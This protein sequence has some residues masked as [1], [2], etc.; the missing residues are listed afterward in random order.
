MDKPAGNLY[1]KTDHMLPVSFEM[2]G[3]EFEKE[4]GE[5]MK[6]RL[7]AS[8]GAFLCLT[9][10]VSIVIT[11]FAAQNQSPP[12]ANT[13]T[14]ELYPTPHSVVY[15]DDGF[16]LTD[17]VTLICGEGIDAPT[18]NRAVQALAAQDI[19][20]VDAEQP[21]EGRSTL[22]IGMNG[23]GSAADA[24]TEQN[25]LKEEGLFDKMDSYILSA[26]DGM[27]SILGKDTDAAF[28]GATTLKHILEQAQDRNIRNLTI[29]D[30]SDSEYRG[31]IEGYYGLPWSNEDRK[32]LM[33][34]GG[35][36]KMTTYVFAPK[37]DPYHNEHWRTLYPQD[38]LDEI[39]DMVQT[40]IDSKCRFVWTIHPFMNQGINF[41]ANYENDLQVIKTKFQQL[42]DVGVR[43][44][45][46]LADD[47]GALSSTNMVRLMTDLDQWV[48]E[49]E[50]VEDLL[51]CPPGYNKGWANVADLQTWRTM[52]EDVHIFWTGD[53]VC[54]WVNQGTFDYFTQH[55]GREALMWLNW[56]VNDINKVRLL[57][58]PGEVMGKNVTG[59]E[60]IV[61]NPMQ[62]AECSKTALFA[63]ADYTWN[64]GAFN[65]DKSWEDCFK[66]IEPD[67]AE[68]LH[69]MAKHLQDP[70]PN[71]HGLSLPESVELNPK[72]ESFKTKYVAGE[73]IKEIGT[74]LVAEFDQII[75]ATEAFPEKSKNEDLKDEM[76]PWRLSLQALSKANKELIQTAI[77][78]EEHN[79]DAVWAH[80][81][82]GTAQFALSKTFPVKNKDAVQLVE[83]GSK[84]LIPFATTLSRQLSEPVKEIVAPVEG[85][86]V[87]SSLYTN[88]TSANLHEGNLNNIVDGN[89][90]T[91]AWINRYINQGDYVGLQFSK[92][93]QITGVRVVQGTNGKPKDAFHYGKFQYSMDGQ[94]WTDLNNGQTYGPYQTNIQLN[95]L[96]IT[97]KYIRFIQDGA[98][99]ADGEANPKWP[100]FRTFEVT[101][102]DTGSGVYTNV[103]ALKDWALEIAADTATLSGD[104]ATLAAGEYVGMKLPRIRDLSSVVVTADGAEKLTLETSMNTKEWSAFD[105]ADPR[106][107]RYVRLINRGAEAVV[108][109]LDALT[110]ASN[111]I[112]PISLAANTIGSLGGDAK[113]LFDGDWTTQTQFKGSQANGRY[114]TYDLGQVIHLDSLKFVLSDGEWDFPRNADVYVSLDNANWEKILTI[115]D[116]RTD[117]TLQDVF[118]AHEI[119][120]NTL[121]QT[122]IDK[123][124]RYLK[125]NLTSGPGPSDKWV[126]LNEIVLNGGAYIPQENN[127]TFISDPVEKQGH[128]A[129]NLTD[130][131]LSTT[132][133]PD[134]S[135]ADNGVLLYRLSEG[136]SLRQI[137]IQQS[138]N[139]LSNA[140]VLVRLAGQQNFVE[141]GALSQSFNVFDRLPEG[142]IVELQIVWDGIAPELHELIVIE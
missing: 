49:K 29:C 99:K 119:S 61:S 83:A 139:T 85:D 17:T 34:F 14:Y 47:A 70:T 22:L 105:P 50:G 135:K 87:K 46:V 40:G 129:S 94:T 36:F 56:P 107:A 72:L 76:E 82:E 28:Y 55:T 3:K 13:D 4:E 26:N 98:L 23:D 2:T 101:Q 111:E 59:F 112:A 84:R 133:L 123:D 12:R 113:N 58:G 80:Y 114:F 102:K 31:F 38:K 116:G 43:Q 124:V 67:A 21:V 1:N 11:A 27:I 8:L 9:L 19:Q 78:L 51:F 18:K 5:N 53:G 140:R 30:Y 136:K 130:G 128:A 63:V 15:A 45:G 89:D 6:K 81:S 69:T 122:G 79:N 90:G 132:Y 25:S 100:A 7:Q 91:H 16:E 71:G 73:S 10:L 68:E 66:Y 57:M 75:E 35:E 48:K 62:Q 110:V 93:A 33:R 120:Y 86:T 95:N 96:D 142:D 24:Y 117:V 65:K 97:A 42:Y 115:G 125:V 54:G 141:I 109:N 108:C 60:G 121:T 64:I 126:R 104:T 137:N 92:P 39:A 103:E 74:E 138:P 131:D 106:P 44:F 127:P 134:S 88:F 20:A 32:S 37:D 118:P 41:G 77:A 52:P